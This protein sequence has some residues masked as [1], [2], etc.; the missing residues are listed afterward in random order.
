LSHGLFAFWMHLM[1]VFVSCLLCASM[2][3]LIYIDWV[4]SYSTVVA[5]WICEL[6]VCV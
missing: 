1:A 4:V 5:N 2:C 3:C 6:N